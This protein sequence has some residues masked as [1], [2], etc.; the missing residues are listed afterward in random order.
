F[1]QSLAHRAAA[2]NNLTQKDVPFK[3]GP[4][5]VAAQEDLKQALLNSPVIR[6]INYTSNAPVILTVD[7]LSIMIGY[8]LVQCDHNNP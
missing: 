4:S 5:Q 8:F 6:A 3:F 1:I 2:L 7:T